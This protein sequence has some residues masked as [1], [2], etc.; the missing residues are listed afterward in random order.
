MLCKTITY[1][2][3]GLLKTLFAKTTHG[4]SPFQF[5]GKVF[6]TDYILRETYDE[7][8]RRVVTRMKKKKHESP[9]QEKTFPFKRPGVDFTKV[10][11]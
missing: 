3:K 11:C 4:V 9:F 7:F 2:G 8:V 1:Q 10:A 5:Q 6:L